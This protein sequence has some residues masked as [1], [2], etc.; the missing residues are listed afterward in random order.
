MD[1][2]NIFFFVI[3]VLY[4]LYY[5]Y[6]AVVQYRERN[7]VI[8]KAE[9]N[10]FTIVNIVLLIL[11]FG[12]STYVNMH[13]YCS[14]KSFREEHSIGFYEIINDQRMESIVKKSGEY[15]DVFAKYRLMQIRMARESVLIY[16]SLILFC[17]ILL[18]VER[19][20]FEQGGIR[21]LSKLTLWGKYESY[22][23]EENEIKFLHKK[24]S[25]TNTY[26]IKD[27]EKDILD[28][29]LKKNVYVTEN[30]DI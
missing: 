14:T 18:S 19:V 26:E 15:D 3:S 24:G 17:L 13:G 21:T 12:F 9:Y 20:R 8:I 16:S 22:E 6:S 25:R 27:D 10:K 5:V 11:G 1:K 30:K 4:I 28:N 7:K 29:Y 23:W 2:E